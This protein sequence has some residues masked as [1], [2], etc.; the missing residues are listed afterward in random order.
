MNLKNKDDMLQRKK[1]RKELLQQKAETIPEKRLSKLAK[2]ADDK[3][4][5]NSTLNDRMRAAAH[6]YVRDWNLSKAMIAAGYSE[7]YAKA[8]GC[9][10]LDNASFKEY[11]EEIQKDIAKELGF[12]KMQLIDIL[13]NH[14]KA[15]FSNLFTDWM[16]R[17][18]FNTIKKKHP[19]ILK[20]IKEISTQIRRVKLKNKQGYE[21]IEYVKISLYDSQ[22]AIDQIF[23]AMGWNEPKLMKVEQ[24]N[25]INLGSG[26]IQGIREAFGL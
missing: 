26:N 20:S 6:Y 11:V 21:E 2:K 9:K 23:K 19:E 3:I 18:E 7:N 16:T 1:S 13:L 25:T 10:L 15:N 14:T 22:K 17:K 5:K 8:N 24:E 12:S 4:L